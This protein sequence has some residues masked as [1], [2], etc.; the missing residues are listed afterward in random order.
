MKPPNILLITTDQQRFDHLGLAGVK[1]EWQF[2]DIYASR[3]HPTSW[4]WSPPP[5]R[6]HILTHKSGEQHGLEHTFG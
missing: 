1:G 3:N 5:T 2:K 6:R 4:R